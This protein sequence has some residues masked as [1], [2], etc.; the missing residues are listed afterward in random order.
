MCVCAC[1]HA[2]AHGMHVLHMHEY[3]KTIVRGSIVYACVCVCVCV[4][5][6]ACV[7]TC[8]H[9]CTQT[10]V[11]GSTVD[12]CPLTVAQLSLNVIQPLNVSNQI[13]LLQIQ[14]IPL[15]YFVVVKKKIN[16]PVSCSFCQHRI[17]I[18]K[19]VQIIFDK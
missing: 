5:V 9:T 4:R 11:G 18:N 1:M 19:H 10:V 12:P 8:T 17:N 14:N 13:N 2:C 6:H 16:K 7:C 3:L 15:S